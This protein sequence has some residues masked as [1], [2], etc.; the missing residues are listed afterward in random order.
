M[1]SVKSI[2]SVILLMVDAMFVSGRA[3]VSS[4]LY[5]LSLGD[6]LCVSVSP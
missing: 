3:V 5:F 4:I 6:Y 2:M 1:Q